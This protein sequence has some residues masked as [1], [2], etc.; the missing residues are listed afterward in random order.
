ML[1]VFQGFCN[2]SYR[3]HIFQKVHQMN[4]YDFFGG[5]VYD[6]ETLIQKERRKIET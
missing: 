1:L 3:S 6:C 5:F 4:H 2:E